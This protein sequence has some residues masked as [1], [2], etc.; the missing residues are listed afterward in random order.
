MTITP[1]AVDLTGRWPWSPAAAPA[2]VAA[3]P[4]GSPPSAPRSPIWERDPETCASGGR[5]IGG[6]GRAPPTSATAAQVDAAL[7]RTVDELGTVVDPGQQRRRGVLRRRSWR[8]SRERLG[9]AV[10]RQPHATCSCARS[11]WRGRWSRPASAAASSTSPRSRASRAAP[12]YAA[13]A[14]AKAG[15]INYTQTAALELAPHGIR[16][17]ALA[18]DITITEGLHGDRAAGRRDASATSCRWAGPAT[19]TR[20]P[21]PPSSSPRTSSSY[22]T[23]QTLHVDGGT[24]AARGWYHHPSGER[25][26]IGPP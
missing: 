5:E 17:N 23:G 21:A 11:G 7:A 19:S 18:P 22:V 20:W 1:A 15:V 6:L 8:R 14:A 13:Y 3:S 4:P 24:S 26:I 16:V 12:G 10:P 2:S 9:R 25:Y